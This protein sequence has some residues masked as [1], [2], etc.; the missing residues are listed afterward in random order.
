MVLKSFL[1]VSLI[2]PMSSSWA[3]FPVITA[4]DNIQ[5]ARDLISGKERRSNDVMPTTNQVNQAIAERSLTVTSP[6]NP[7]PA[8]RQQA[9]S[10]AERVKQDVIRHGG[11]APASVPA[12][13][14]HNVVQIDSPTDAAAR[15][16]RDV[17]RHGGKIPVEVKSQSG[18]IASP[19]DPT[20]LMRDTLEAAELA[21]TAA[22]LQK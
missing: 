2:L 11:Q 17:I 14:S 7:S 6:S 19:V 5:H 10:E 4:D 18:Q 1:L 20:K 15:V 13:V 3:L 9:G 22:G 12:D 21:K 8:Q 16:K